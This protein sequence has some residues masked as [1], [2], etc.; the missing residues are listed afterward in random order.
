MKRSRGRL[1]VYVWLAALA[2]ALVAGRPTQEPSD[3]LHDPCGLEDPEVDADNHVV[4]A[5]P[6][7]APPALTPAHHRADS[8]KPPLS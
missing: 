7:A 2:G 3:P 5:A 6:L 4:P 8:V 1:A